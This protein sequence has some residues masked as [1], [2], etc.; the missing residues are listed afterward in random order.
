MLHPVPA[1]LKI[2]HTA[3]YAMDLV[4]KSSSHTT[5]YLSPTFRLMSKKLNF[6]SSDLH[7]QFGSSPGDSSPA[8][9]SIRSKLSKN[10]HTGLEK[11]S[12][13]KLHGA[14]ARNVWS[15][16]F[17]SS[18]SSF[19]LET[20]VHGDQ[21]RCS[22]SNLEFEETPSFVS[23]K[24][25][26]HVVGV[27]SGRACL[28]N[29]V[30]TLALE[31]NVVNVYL[32]PHDAVLNDVGKSIVQGKTSSSNV[33]PYD[34]V[35]LDGT[36]QIV[37][38]GDSGV[39]DHHCFFE[40]TDGSSVEKSKST[41][42]D[43]SNTDL[44]NRKIVQY[45]SYQNGGD[46]TGGHGTHV[47]G[48]IVGF[49]ESLSL[50]DFKGHASG[51]KIAFY[52][53]STDGNSIYYQ[54]PLSTKVFQ[55]AYD[56]GARLHSNSWGSSPNTYDAGCADIDKYHYETDDFLVLFAAGNDG[57]EG[58]YSVGTPATSKNSMAIGA[59]RSS[60]DFGDM[61]YFSSMGP[62]FDYRFK[63]DVSAPGFYTFSSNAVSGGSS[64]CGLTRKA[65]T[66]MATP[67]VAGNGAIVRQ[68]FVDS[69]YWATTCN[70]GYSKCGAFSPRG[71][72]VK[73]TLIHSG[74]AMVEYPG[75]STEGQI[76]LGTVP[77]IIQ[78]FGRISLSNVLPLAGTT[79]SGFDLFVDE[80][81]MT[82]LTTQT[83]TVTVTS[84]T[85]PLKV[86]IV[87]MDLPADTL[88][89]K[90]LIH[91]IDLKVIAP[92]GA[93]SYGNEFAGDEENN[94]E[95][96]RISS[97]SAGTYTVVLTA[98]DIMFV[99]G[100]ADSASQKV[101]VVITSVGS[102][103]GPSSGVIS[104]T[105]ANYPLGCASGESQVVLFKVDHGTNGWGSS[106]TYKIVRTSDSVEVKTG[107]LS[108]ATKGNLYEKETFCLPDNTYTVQL[109]LDGSNTNQVGL[110]IHACD[111]FLDDKLTTDSFT[112]SSN[113][114]GACSENTL[115]LGLK[116]SEYGIPYGW[117]GDSSYVIESNGAGVDI[118]GTLQVGIYDLRG[119]CLP[120]GLY[121]V[122]FSGIPE[123]DDY[124]LNYGGY[125]GYY[126]IQE[127]E[128]SFTCGSDDV[129]LR[130]FEC[131]D[132]TRVCV[133]II[134][135]AVIE[136][137]GGSCD[138]ISITTGDTTIPKSGNSE[139]DD[140]DSSILRTIIFLVIVL[141]LITITVLCCLFI[142][143]SCCGK[144]LAEDSVLEVQM[145]D[146]MGNRR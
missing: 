142:K 137:S 82:S 7:I 45:I 74:D 10:G 38:V 141:G 2:H 78:G 122:T 18:L 72:T 53:M 133:R 89:T 67:A 139:E 8:I 70:S 110:S 140:D 99:S 37:G 55:P 134:E 49:D 71:A 138:L 146:A 39:D 29:L 114:C 136:Y 90:V 60:A 6:E 5:H 145:P 58:F 12:T 83:Y 24:G 20:A 64:T 126:G 21:D 123:E 1:S 65:G 120:D 127:Y 103:S 117:T 13:F 143:R 25:L 144:S 48:T 50:D 113:T 22:Y 77:D 75:G 44:T 119:F 88:S 102:V 91:D 97:P 42:A 93:V 57:S 33:H 135:L 27:E 105:L 9:S 96:V 63:P 17:S 106:N 94:V 14:T 124:G 56:A 68:F 36:G 19:P 40:N 80:L 104:S 11:M 101:S 30:A 81:S 41:T 109:V 84:S 86:T 111:V 23:V 108:S 73:A 131:N 59:T 43:S 61:A 35:G 3:L 121:N 79:V 98:K 128:M 107:T 51:A 15:E 87:W 112:V 129:T 130:A 52:D 69:S 46:I 32:R 76:T 54:Q 16:A 132:Y 62:T 31:P 66:S 125:R 116:G 100:F 34:D 26:H 28:A 92:G 115:N 118:V 4:D 95:Q 85:A 47:C